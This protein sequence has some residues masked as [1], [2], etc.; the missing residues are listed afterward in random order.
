MDGIRSDASLIVESLVVEANTSVY[1]PHQ[2]F[3]TALAAGCLS[4]F[5]NK[6]ATAQLSGPLHHARSLSP[7]VSER[8]GLRVS[9]W[10]LMPS[11][12]CVKGTQLENR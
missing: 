8:E 9:F 4:V 3:P 2:S 5:P 7:S 1:Q 12:M 10:E 11:G 6:I